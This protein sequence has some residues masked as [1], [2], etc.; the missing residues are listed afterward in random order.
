MARRTF[1]RIADELERAIRSDPSYALPTIV[2]LSNQWRVTYQTMWKAL[3]VL[4]RKGVVVAQTGRKMAVAAM[5]GRPEQD[6]TSSAD[7]LHGAIKDRITAGVYR[8]GKPFPKKDFFVYSERVSPVTVARAFTSLASDGLAHKRRSRWIVVRWGSPGSRGVSGGS[9][10]PAGRY[11]LD[12]RG[13]GGPDPNASDA[14]THRT[15][16]GTPW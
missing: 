2:E 3:Q 12:D 15:R 1:N 16:T 10:T 14:A 13:C 6:A 7:R 5:P 8:A 9:W 4:A 11:G